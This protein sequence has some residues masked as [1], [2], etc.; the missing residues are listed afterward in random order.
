MKLLLIAKLFL[1]LL[2][3]SLPFGSTA[4]TTI[5]IEAGLNFSGNTPN[6]YK[7]FFLRY[8]HPGLDGGFFIEKNIKKKIAIRTSLIYSVRF[9]LYGKPAPFYRALHCITLPVLASFK[10]NAKLSFD[11]GIELI[12]IAATELPYFST[13]AI[14]LGPKVAIAYQINPAFAL[15]LYGV[16]DLIKIRQDNAPN[17][18]NFNYYNN[19][20]L[21]LK[22]AYTFKRFKKRR[23][24]RSPG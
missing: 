12:A 10:V 13:P 2:L 20:A 24:I 6:R 17:S 1:L 22:V 21:G 7:T 11:L 14:H 16:Y 8:F 19:V 15:R 4:Q 9:F 23:I 5:G 18:T 3:L